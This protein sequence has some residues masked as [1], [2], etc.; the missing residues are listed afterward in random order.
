MSRKKEIKDCLK[1]VLLGL[2]AIGIVYLLP[3]PDNS[4]IFLIL[5]YLLYFLSSLYV[6]F[7]LFSFYLLFTHK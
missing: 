3:N 2:I 5:K 4:W 6:I 7:G 1:S